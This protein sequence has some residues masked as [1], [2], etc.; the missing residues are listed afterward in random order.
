MNVIR[1]SN[2]G[3]RAPGQHSATDFTAVPVFVRHV[4]A[5]ALSRLCRLGP[6]SHHRSRNQCEERIRTDR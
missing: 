4:R 5:F 3:C 6:L 1:H 2:Y